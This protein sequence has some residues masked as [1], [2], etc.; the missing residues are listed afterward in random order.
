MSRKR[1]YEEKFLDFLI[2][3]A[4][5]IEPSPYFGPRVAALAKDQ[6]ADFMQLMSNIARWLLPTFATLGVVVLLI[7]YQAST[8]PARAS[9]PDFLFEQE[10]S[11]QTVTT[12][13]VL[14]SLQPQPPVD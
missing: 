2:E 4:P 5:E 14:D 3:N 6:S 9:Y 11:E 13:Y 8:S 12:E 1:E 10:S 7:S